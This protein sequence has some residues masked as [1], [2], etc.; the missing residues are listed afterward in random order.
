MKTRRLQKN[1]MNKNK[2]T[3]TGRILL[4][5]LF[6][7]ISSQ[8]ISALRISNERIST[9][10]TAA[11]IN[12]LTDFPSNSSVHYGVGNY[13][14]SV[15]DSNIL[16]NHSVQISGLNPNSLYDLKIRSENTQESAQRVGLSF[17]TRQDEQVT[18]PTINTSLP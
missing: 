13:A 17:V 16:T 8:T 5:L 11:T 9:T 18:P 4:V 7:F 6:M 14:Q 15:K 1:K 3:K 12:W 10:T 2:F